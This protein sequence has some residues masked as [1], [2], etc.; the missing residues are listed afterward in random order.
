MQVQPL[1]PRG[2]DGARQRSPHSTDKRARSPDRNAPRDHLVQGF[3]TEQQVEQFLDQAPLFE[4][5][6][7]ESGINL[8][9]YSHRRSPTMLLP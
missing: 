5:M 9:K 6:L 8:T 3:A 2:G 1:H 4:R 7:V